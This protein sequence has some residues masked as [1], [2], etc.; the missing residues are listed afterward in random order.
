M[1]QSAV[2]Y[3]KNST[4]GRISFARSSFQILSWMAPRRAEKRAVALFTRPRRLRRSRPPSVPGLEARFEFCGDRRLSVW[5]FGQG[6]AILLVHG[7]NGHAGQMQ[8]FI[9]P[10]VDS[11]FRV[12]AFD[13][14]GHGRS[15]EKHVTVLDLREAI[16][17]VARRFGPIHGLIA[18][19]L[20][21]TASV[22]AVHGGLAV[23]RMVVMA[24]P[25]EVPYFVRAFASSLGLR[26]DLTGGMLDLVRRELGGDLESLDLRRIAPQMHIPLLVIHDPE[27]YEV[28]FSH[29]QSLAAA[30]PGAQLE[31]LKGYGHR[32]LLSA[33]KSI[34]RAVAF[35]ATG[36]DLNN[37]EIHGENFELD[38]YLFD[39]DV[40]RWELSG[41]PSPLGDV[42]RVEDQRL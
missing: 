24:P 1:S 16:L 11:G 18:H 22:L 39:R 2:P 35:T 40:R 5:E 21:A 9:K 19:S 29:G 6:P 33:P 25:V 4:N 13:H 41:S 17:A 10:L 23:E 30:W 42:H 31:A 34:E 8:G 14:P 32:R 26:K 27:D 28:P 15:S 36:H 12:V 38:Q 7:W 3:L 37:W 20:G